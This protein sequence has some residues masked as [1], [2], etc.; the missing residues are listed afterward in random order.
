MFKEYFMKSRLFT[1]M[2]ILAVTLLFGC[3]GQDPKKVEIYLTDATGKP[4]G[5]ISSKSLVA[6]AEKP[7]G[8]EGGNS[9]AKEED[10]ISSID[11]NI[12]QTLATCKQRF[13]DT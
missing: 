9:I 12:E 8:S 2:S 13:P 3:R 4:Q 6:S 1:I 7:V 5:S 10:S 11:Q